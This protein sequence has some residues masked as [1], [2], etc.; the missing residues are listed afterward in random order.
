VK[1]K[2]T[3]KRECNEISRVV[4]KD[5]EI[6]LGDELEV[7]SISS[8]IEKGRMEERGNLK[9]ALL[10]D[11]TDSLIGKTFDRIPLLGDVHQLC[12][13]TAPLSRSSNRETERKRETHRYTG[14]FPQPP[15]QLPITSSYDITPVLSHSVDDTI[16]CVGSFVTTR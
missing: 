6:R 2:E 14:N 5:S 12:T 13:S 4:A 10:V 15:P 7:E 11:L 8:K 16:I 3:V 9:S 1:E